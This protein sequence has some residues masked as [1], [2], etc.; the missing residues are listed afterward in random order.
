MRKFL[1]VLTGMIWVAMPLQAFDLSQMTDAERQ[2]FRDEVRSYLLEYPEVLME[3]IEVL[4]ARDEQQAA[5]DAEA[6]RAADQE[7][8]S[9]YRDELY[10]DGYS[11][12]GGNLNGDLTIVEFLDYRCTYCRRAHPELTEILKQ[13]GNI[14]WIVKEYPILGPESVNS[15]KVA[16]ATLQT[17]G[18]DAYLRMHDVLMSYDGPV[19]SRTIDRLAKSAKVDADA[20]LAVYDSEAVADQIAQSRELGMKMRVSGTPTFAIGDLIV[21]GYLPAPQFLGAIEHGRSLSN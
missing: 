2:Q 13:D 17:Q 20:I 4:R 15:S 10:N 19:N 18:P 8:V 5:K 1:I 3:A 9:Q 16:I 11:Y 12:V 21:R 6:E 14:R 7:L